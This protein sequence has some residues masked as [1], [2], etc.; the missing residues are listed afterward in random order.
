MV[1]VMQPCSSDTPILSLADFR[2]W[3]VWM[4]RRETVMRVARRLHCSQPVVYQ[5]MMGTR[6]PSRQVRAL[7]ALLAHGSHELEE[8]LPQRSTR[9]PKRTPSP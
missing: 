5:W 2:F 8:G 4:G 7:A 1:S 9:K 6:K 3:L